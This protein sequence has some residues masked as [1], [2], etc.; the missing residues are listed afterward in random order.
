M[1]IEENKKSLRR[2][3][4]EV[5]NNNNLDLIPELVSPG[6]VSHV[7]PEYRGHEGLRQHIIDARQAFSDMHLTIVHIF[8]EGDMVG[9][10]VTLEGTH[11][12]ELTGQT[13]TNKKFSSTAIGI[14]RMENS[15]E[16]ERWQ[17]QKQGEPSI[18]QQLIE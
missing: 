9:W 11:T 17:G 13:P 6:F 7:I 14:S 12:G 16:A 15:K 4:E 2:L 8:A 3:F 18:Y 5:Y 10:S 1:G